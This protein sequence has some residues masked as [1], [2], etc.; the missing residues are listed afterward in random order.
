MPHLQRV[1]AEK[2]EDPAL[3]ALYGRALAAAKQY[4]GAEQ[5]FT[6]ALRQR[7]ESLELRVALGLT[8][9]Q[10]GKRDRAA[11]ILQ[12]VAQQHPRDPHALLA[13]AQARL[14]RK[15]LAQALAVL[16][17]A[18]RHAPDHPAVLEL[19]ARTASDLGFH[20]DAALAWSEY[21]KL[22]PSATYARRERAF[23]LV[24]AKDA[25][26]LPELEAYAKAFPTDAIAMYQLGVA[27]APTDSGKALEQ[28]DR[29]LK[30]MPDNPD[31][32][33]VRGALLA[34]E[35][36][37]EE[38]R[39]DLERSVKLNPANA[40]ALSRLGLLYRTA[41]DLRSAETTLRRASE[42]DPHDRAALMHLGFVLRAQGRLAEAEPLFA[43]LKAQLSAPRSSTRAGLLEFLNL[44]PERQREEYLANLRKA[45]EDRP[46][47]QRL[48]LQLGMEQLASGDVAGAMRNF[49]GL[50]QAEALREA[51]EALIDAGEYQ[52]ALR[53]P[54]ERTQSAERL[55]AQ[56]RLASDLQGAV[57]AMNGAIAL[58]PE[59]AFV[60][61]QA[62]R[63]LVGHQRFNEAAS[64]L[65]QAV[66]RV[67]EDRNLRL[68]Y[69]TALELSKRFAHAREVL[70]GIHQRWPEWSRPYLVHAISFMTRGKAAEGMPLLERALALGE[71]SAE[72]HYYRAGTDRVVSG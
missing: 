49:E 58:A 40:P 52:G 21:L 30:T 18:R 57:Q 7:P 34:R 67:P 44:D 37:T 35:G 54:G 55:V 36:R 28:L 63:L 43:R 13:L 17:E 29:A 59:R 69:A 32:L 14:A 20:N 51:A 26:G 39:R 65:E 47:D 66:R 72:V 42:L 61:R 6:S 64:L 19:L 16:G 11:E 48:R 70:A 56:A 12:S 2:A 62:Y 5:A 60:Y 23:A 15:E 45:V 50:S 1:G 8:L 71:N 68:E 27:Y 38:A 53:L 4:E 41:G 9:L 33:Y 22:V 10:A 3:L 46:E 25:K 24:R 31:A